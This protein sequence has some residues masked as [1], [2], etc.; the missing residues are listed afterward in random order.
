[1][2]SLLTFCSSNNQSVRQVMSSLATNESNHHYASTLGRSQTGSN[3]HAVGTMLPL[4][5]GFTSLFYHYGKLGNNLYCLL[6]LVLR[7]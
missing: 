3:G 6:V 4:G 2:L 7:G 1:M 5:N